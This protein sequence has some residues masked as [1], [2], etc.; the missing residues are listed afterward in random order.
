MKNKIIKISEAQLNEVLK[1]DY[2]FSYLG[3]ESSD[4]NHASEVSA[5]VP[6]DSPDIDP[7]PI[8]ADTISRTLSN[9]SWWN[10]HY[11]FNGYRI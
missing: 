5:N 8:D 4:T 6:L 2:P 3:N 1:E 7:V 11:G 9:N 10:R